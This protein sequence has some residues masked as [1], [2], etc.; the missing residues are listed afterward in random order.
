MAIH[1]HRH[2]RQAGHPRAAR[3]G[4]QHGFGL[5][6]GVL[7]QQHM[8]QA[9]CLRHVGQPAVASLTSGVFGAFAEAVGYHHRMQPQRYA[10]PRTQIANETLKVGRSGL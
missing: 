1:L 6:I 8:A 7:R 4:Q 2:T 10:E 3:Q 9:L 5:I